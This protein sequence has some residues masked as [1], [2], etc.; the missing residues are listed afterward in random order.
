MKILLSPAKSINTDVAIPQ[1]YFTFPVFA[2]EAEQ[3]AKKLS[4]LNTK[5]NN[6]IDGCE[7]VY[8]QLECRA[9]SEF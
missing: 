8:W 9:L 6:G 4:K 5:K 3:L 7:C 2:K 1:K